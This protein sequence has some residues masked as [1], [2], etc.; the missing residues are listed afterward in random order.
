MIIFRDDDAPVHGMTHFITVHEMLREAGVVHTVS[1]ICRNL[2]RYT[3]FVNYV[4][5]D[6]E[7]FDPQFHCLDHI[8]HTQNHDIVRDQFEQGV[9]EFKD[10]FGFTPSVWYPTWNKTD[11]FCEV[12]AAAL[13]MKTNAKKYSFGQFLR[14]SV[15]VKDSGGVLNFHHWAKEER[16]VLPD[17]IKL[18]KNG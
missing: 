14:K 15:A 6:P 1:I 17:I 5:S 12:E 18:Y 16:D 10:S 9:K 4:N 2:S 7:Y 13:G 3:E 11:N 8:D